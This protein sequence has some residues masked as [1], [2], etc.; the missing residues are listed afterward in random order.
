[1]LMIITTA[2]ITIR[3]SV[4]DLRE[5]GR[6]TQGVRV[7]NLSEGDAIAAVAKVDVEDTESDKESDTPNATATDIHPTPENPT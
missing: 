7:I 3:M 4:S 1:D 5:M 6:N 2:G